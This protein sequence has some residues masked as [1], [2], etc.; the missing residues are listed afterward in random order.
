MSIANAVNK[1]LTFKRES[2]WKVPAGTGSAQEFRRVS[3]TFNLNKEAYESAEIR[4]DYQTAVSRHGVR[5]VSGSL[6]GELSPG[7]YSDFVSAI[8]ARDFTSGV[9]ISS[10]TLT[11]AASGSNWTITRD[12]GSF[13]TG[14][15]KIGDVVRLSGASLN[16]GNVAKNLFV[17]NVTATVLT[18]KVLNGSAL[19]A[20]SAIASCTVTVQ[21]KK[22]FVP[23]TGHT[24]VSYNA[25]E[26]YNDI[27]QCELYV[28]NKVQSCAVSLPT[29][30]FATVELSFMG[31]DLDATNTGSS[32][33]FVSPTAQATSNALAA[34]NGAML[35]DNAAVAILTSLNFTINREVT[36]LNAVGSNTAVDASAGRITVS[37]SGSVYF[38]DATYRDKFVNE[39]ET[40]L[41]VVMTSDNTANA[42]FLAFT[43]PRV[44]VNSINKT[45][46]TTGIVASFDFTALV[47]TDGGS[48]TTTEKTTISIQ[49]SLA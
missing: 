5:S 46:D 39:T 4:T 37:G 6:S 33:Y 49:D 3:G 20:Q 18:V 45:D 31:A 25:E 43:L 42:D 23:S 22:T 41:A 12:A 36:M 28:G 38:T 17:L 21:G 34:V 9:S 10:L 48:G 32:R 29:T 7:S 27:S 30:G 15:I 26:W 11:I 19:T 2:T 44:K 40:T 8:V 1:S 24:D 13:L 16:A 35:V 14:G 47:D